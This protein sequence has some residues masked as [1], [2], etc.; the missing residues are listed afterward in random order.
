M[1]TSYKRGV[2]AFDEDAPVV[3]SRLIKFWDAFGQSFVGCGRAEKLHER[4]LFP[5]C[6][7][8][9]LVAR[10]VEKRQAIF[11]RPGGVAELG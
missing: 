10:R 8:R 4:N 11:L 7:R 6:S 5:K 3:V 1:L 2:L 9:K